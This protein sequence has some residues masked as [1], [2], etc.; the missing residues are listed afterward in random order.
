MQTETLSTAENAVLGIT[1]DGPANLE[2]VYQRLNTPPASTRLGVIA[3]AVVSLREKRLIA[4]SSRPDAADEASGAHVYKS[5]F[6]ATAEGKEL[7]GRPRPSPEG[8]KS[9]RGAWKHLGID[10]SYEDFRQARREAWACSPDEP[11]VAGPK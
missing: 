5:S 6:Q 7:A 4:V 3:K 1:A 11:E 8:R 2:A 10:L 9:P